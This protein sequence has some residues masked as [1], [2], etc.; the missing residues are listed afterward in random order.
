MEDLCLAAI[1]EEPINTCIV[2]FFGC[3]QH[4]ALAIPKELSKA[5]VRVF[6]SSRKDPT[7]PLGVAAMKGYWPLDNEA[8]EPLR[9]FLKSL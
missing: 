6:L 8:F 4:N 7:L 2:D 9:R 3:L 1:D 5:K